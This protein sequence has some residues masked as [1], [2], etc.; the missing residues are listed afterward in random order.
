MSFAELRQTVLRAHALSTDRFAED[1][2]LTEAGEARTVRVKIVH[3]QAGP[4][5]GRRGV[6][7]DNRQGTVEEREWIE[8]MCSRDATWEKAI[9]TR[10]EYSAELRRDVDRDADQRPFVFLGE[11]VFEGDQSATYIFERPR[12]LVQGK[13]T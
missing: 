7:P 9:A 1:A 5:A 4:R 12:R 8:V 6:V 10:P 3:E 11:V 13:G 2:E